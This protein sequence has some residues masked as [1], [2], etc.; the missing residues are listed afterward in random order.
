MKTAR[1][2]LIIFSFVWCMLITHTVYTGV[3]IDHDGGVDDV[4]SAVLQLQYWKEKVRAITIV[5][6]DCYGYPA[7][8]VMTQLKNTL[9][10]NHTFP[11]GL[12]SHEGTNCFPAEW[13][14]DA[15]HIA[16]LPFWKNFIDENES[17]VDHVL[18]AHEILT[19]VLRNADEPMTILMTGPCTNIAQ[20]VREHPE[21]RH[22][23]ARMYMMGGAL[24]VPGNV[25]EQGH[26]GSAEWN[27]Y[28]NPT[29]FH[30]L[31]C[32]G[33]PLTLVTLDATC[34]IP[35]R[36]EF[37]ATLANAACTNTTCQLVCDCLQIIMP[38]IENG[39]YYFW[40]TLA[41][42]ALINP[43]IITTKKVKIS[44]VTHGESMGSI[45]EDANGYEVDVAVGADLALF[46]QTVL[47]ILVHHAL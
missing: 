39:Q 16:R 10:A 17:S 22:K 1:K 20:V 28:N 6:G 19:T 45:V 43:A 18:S 34:H 31:L 15:W 7:A 41:S 14:E 11:I 29:A 47:D 12:S 9:C 38:F 25:Q 8:W 37:I 24:Y 30:D 13:R 46:E 27:I 5:P 3:I 23:I 26:D 35:I 44:V 21:L 32:S 33:V 2:K 42:A 40:D 4:I 36:K